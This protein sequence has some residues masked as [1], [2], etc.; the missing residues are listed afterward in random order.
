M[1]P[2]GQIKHF[3]HWL[4]AYIHIPYRKSYEKRHHAYDRYP[5]PSD[6]A[7][8]Y[9][10]PSFRGGR[11][12]LSVIAQAPYLTLRMALIRANCWPDSSFDPLRSPREN[13]R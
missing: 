6:E 5:S 1:T 12:L 7:D 8:D 4:L 13:S 10:F 3:A 2:G 11:R 9:F